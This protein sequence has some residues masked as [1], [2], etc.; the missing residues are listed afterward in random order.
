MHSVMTAATPVDLLFRGMDKLG[1]GSDVDTLHVLRLLPEHQFRIVV[2]AGCGAGRQTIVLARELQMTIHAADLHQPFLDRL[3]ARA[4]TLGLDHLIQIHQLDISKIPNRFPETDLLWA[5][6]SAYT[7]GFANA[8]QTWAN[9]SNPHRFVVVSE[10][11]WLRNESPE[12][13]AKFFRSA[14]P[15]MKSVRQNIAIAEKAGY[16]VLATHTLPKHAWTD[17]YYDVLEPR[18]RSLATHPDES[19]RELAAV[20]M[21]EMEIF[22]IS[23]DSYGYVFFVLA[24]RCPFCKSGRRH[25][26]SLSAWIC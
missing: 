23:E 18:A 17:G 22:K 13:V 2:D 3:T 4:T 25:S 24:R 6:G 20:T 10:L 7:I 15:E 5:E 1:P 11:C 12:A 26:P 14:Y 21:R 19:V 16:E 8:L 9:A